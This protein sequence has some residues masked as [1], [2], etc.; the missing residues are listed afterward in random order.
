MLQDLAENVILARLDEGDDL[1][2]SAAT[3]AQE[4]TGL[5]DTFNEHGP[6]A[7]GEPGRGGGYC[8]LLI[9]GGLIRLGNLILLGNRPCRGGLL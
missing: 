7:A 5:V 3:G 8:L 2:G 4:R 6:A 9:V 1:H